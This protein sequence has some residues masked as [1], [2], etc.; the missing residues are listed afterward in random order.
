MSILWSGESLSTSTNFRYLWNPKIHDRLQKCSTLDI[1]CAR[2]IHSATLK[3]ISLQLILIL[4]SNCCLGLWSLQIFL[5][6]FSIISSSRPF[7]LH[8]HSVTSVT[9]K[10]RAKIVKLLI[11]KFS[12]ASY[13]TALVGFS[14]SFSKTLNVL[15]HF[16]RKAKLYSYTKHQA[17]KSNNISNNNNINNKYK[18]IAKLETRFICSRNSVMRDTTNIRFCHLSS[19]TSLIQFISPTLHLYTAQSRSVS[20]LIGT[21]QSSAAFCHE[22]TC[23]RF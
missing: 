10:W 3:S 7:T 20:S 4:F 6:K 16:E 1:Y 12:P 15:L 19:R 22:A 18:P 8:V 17:N 11:Y 2:L 21:L 13:Y 23:Q 5:I 14:M 9:T